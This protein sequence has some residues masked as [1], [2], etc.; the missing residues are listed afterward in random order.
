MTDG[1]HISQEDLTLY[2][3]H[4]LPA[5]Q[6]AEIRLHVET[7]PACRAELE[8]S[9]GDLALVALGVE[10]QPA[11]EGARERFLARMAAE[12]ATA[13]PVSAGMRSPE[14]AAQRLERQPQRRRAAWI[15]W[16]AAAVLAM[17]AL[18]LGFQ[19]E[20]LKRELEQ[21]AGVAARMSAASARAQEVVEIL[22]SP[23]AER[24]VLTAPKTPAE[25]IGRAVY[26]P[27]RGAL[28][29]QAS[30]LRSLPASR[31]YELWII[32]ANGSAPIPAGLFL[33]DAAGEASVILPP[34]P[35]GIPAKA[36]GVTVEKQAGSDAPTAPILLSGAT[37]G[38][39]S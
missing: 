13:E 1:H 23:L 20:R 11:P 24:V 5:E 39:G 4:A 19:I 10:Q 21:Q 6:A 35:L 38:P 8:E 2:A 25:P 33:P 14:W 12:S 15:P 29:F 30:H 3:M 34:L 28:I 36:F 26:L 17:V 9:A 37:A 16:T 27:S 22:T 18:A 32:P 31:T 7:C